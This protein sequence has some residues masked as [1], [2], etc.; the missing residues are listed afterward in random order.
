MH[1]RNHRIQLF[2]QDELRHY[3]LRCTRFFKDSATDFCQ[4]SVVDSAT[5]FRKTSVV[6]TDG[7]T[8]GFP[9]CTSEIPCTNDLTNNHDR[10]CEAHKELRGVCSVE[11]CDERVELNSLVCHL[12]DHFAAWG[13]HK[14]SGQ[15]HHQL[16]ECLQ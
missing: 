8:L 3:C 2:E 11:G 7:L 9:C 13:A 5:N 10:F 16:Q 15:S 6:V 12:P 4:T 14:E 1:A